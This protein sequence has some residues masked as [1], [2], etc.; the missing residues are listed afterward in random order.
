MSTQQTRFPE[1]LVFDN[2]FTREMPADPIE[3]GGR[4]HD[5]LAEAYYRQEQRTAP[6]PSTARG[7]AGQVSPTPCN[8]R[9]RRC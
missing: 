8:E 4:D 3:S 7:L 9:Y 5:L 6:L 1:N 2:R